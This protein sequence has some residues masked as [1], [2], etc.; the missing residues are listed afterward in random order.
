MHSKD[1]TYVYHCK[2]L[3]TGFDDISVT[4]TEVQGLYPSFRL[5]SVFQIDEGRQEEL[6]ET[7]RARPW[8]IVNLQRFHISHENVAKGKNFIYKI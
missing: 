4:R 8:Q 5:Q 1:C 2:I 6:R 7:K 3:A